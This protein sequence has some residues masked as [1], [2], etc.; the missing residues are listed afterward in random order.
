MIEK[1]KY[2]TTGNQLTYGID[3]MEYYEYIKY[4]TVDFKFLLDEITE[5]RLTLPILTHGQ[6]HMDRY[7]NQQF[8]DMGQQAAQNCGIPE[9]SETNK[10]NPAFSSAY[11]Q[12]TVSSPW[13]KQEEL[14]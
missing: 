2:P 11:Y 8:S 10:V 12:K 1:S 9:R 13:N 5:T 6:I 7:M 14:K 4:N 3:K